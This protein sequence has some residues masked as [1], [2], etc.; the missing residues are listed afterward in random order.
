MNLRMPI[1]CLSLTVTQPFFSIFVLQTES[2]SLLTPTQVAQLTLGSGALN[3]TDQIN[4]VFER[5]EEGD[6]F[7]NVD[8]YLTQLTAE[9]QVIHVFGKHNLYALTLT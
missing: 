3:D 1:L 6:A 5:L 4:L 2:L 7:E 8:E 9:E